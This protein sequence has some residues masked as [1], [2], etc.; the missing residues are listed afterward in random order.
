MAIY[1][2]F[3]GYLLP[4]Y[5]VTNQDNHRLKDVQDNLFCLLKDDKN[6]LN[7]NIISLNSDTNRKLNNNNPG[8]P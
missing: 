5:I 2:L 1:W 7:N 3:I 6:R 8:N 4:V